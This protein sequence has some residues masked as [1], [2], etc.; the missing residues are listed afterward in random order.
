MTNDI[1]EIVDNKGY[2]EKITCGLSMIDDSIG[3]FTCGGNYLVAGHRKSGKSSLLIGFVNHWLTKGITVGYLNSEMDERHLMDMLQA[4]YFDKPKNELSHEDDQ[5]YKNMFRSKFLY[6][7]PDSIRDS[8]G[9]SVTKIESEILGHVHAGARI[10]VA[11]NLTKLQESV[12]NG[13]SGYTNLAAGVSAITKICRSENLLGFT[14]LHTKDDLMFT[15]TPEGIAKAVAD[16]LPEKIFEKSVTIL[17]KPSSASVYGGGSSRTDLLGTILLWRPYQMFSDPNY[18]EL[19]QLIFED[20]R[21]EP[22]PESLRLMFNGSKNKFVEDM[23]EVA[24]KIFE[25]KTNSVS[26]IEQT[27]LQSESSEIPF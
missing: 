2:L 21:G 19:S 20:F 3:G 14:V 5:L 27:R 25:S 11:D 13:K 1:F 8:L 7:D 4:N 16:K 10:I 15:E 9:L 6:S 12:P 18:A 23:A 17:K 26:E 22:P 24:K